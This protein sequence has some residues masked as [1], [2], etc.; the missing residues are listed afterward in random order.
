MHQLS[1]GIRIDVIDVHER[2]IAYYRR[3]GYLLVKDSFFVHPFWKT[4]SRVMVIAADADRPCALQH[5][6][7]DVSNPLSTDQLR[8]VVAIDDGQGCDGN[9]G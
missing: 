3:L 2:A 7:V 8:H 6:F 9:V 4:P 5:V 1:M